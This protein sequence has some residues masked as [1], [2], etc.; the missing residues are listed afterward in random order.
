MLLKCGPCN[1]VTIL[2]TLQL[3]P[4]LF[5]LM[6]R[7]LWETFVRRGLFTTSS[8]S[9]P[10]SDETWQEIGRMCGSV[11]S[12][13]HPGSLNAVPPFGYVPPPWST[14]CCCQIPCPRL[15]MLASWSHGCH[16]LHGQSRL[17]YFL[18]TSWIGA[19]FL[20]KVCLFL[21]PPLSCVL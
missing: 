5:T 15:L 16:D 8:S 17:I 4:T 1:A 9:C 20:W 19:D 3:N 18:L 6:F 10:G 11:C 13:P 7:S 21:L 12:C 14:W 2:I